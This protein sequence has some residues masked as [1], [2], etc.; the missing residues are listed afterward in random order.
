MCVIS[1]TNNR[2]LPDLKLNPLKSLF[3]FP[4]LIIVLRDFGV[5]KL[6]IGIWIGFWLEDR[7]WPNN[8]V[9]V[10]KCV[11]T[12]YMPQY[13]IY[14]KVIHARFCFRGDT[15]RFRIYIDETFSVDRNPPHSNNKLQLHIY[16]K[17]R[18]GLEVIDKSGAMTINRKGNLKSRMQL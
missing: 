14:K 4:I 8:N 5:G 18:S 16:V 7:L 13:D 15:S 6:K 3:E 2:S 9:V 11:F 17:L 12:K 1:C 10:L